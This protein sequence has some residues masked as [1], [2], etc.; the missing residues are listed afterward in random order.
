MISPINQL[1]QDGIFEHLEKSPFFNKHRDNLFT[2]VKMGWNQLISDKV[3]KFDDLDF[4]NY[5]PK[6]YLNEYN[7]LKIIQSDYNNFSFCNYIKGLVSIIIPFHNRSEYTKT[8]FE[9]IILETE[10]PYQV[11]AINNGSNDDTDQL[12][13]DTKVWFEGAPYCIGFE[14]INNI[15]NL[16]FAQSNNLGSSYAKGEFLCFLNND[17]KVTENWLQPLLHSFKDP[18]IGA[19]APLLLYNDN[20]IQHCGTIFHPNRSPE[21]IYNG[22]SRFFPPAHLETVEFQSLT[23]ACL[24]VRHKLYDEIDGFDENY[25]NCFEDI[26]LCLAIRERGYKL[27]YNP[28]SYIFHFESKTPGRKDGEQKSG[29]LLGSKWSRKIVGDASLHYKKGGFHYENGAIDYIERS[30]PA[31]LDNYNRNNL[32]DRDIQLIK[33]FGT[34]LKDYIPTKVDEHHTL[35]DKTTTPLVSIII[36]LFNNL[37]YTRACINSIVKN[38]LYPNYQL[39]LVDNNS[40][41]GTD[42]YLKELKSTLPNLKIITNSE[43]LGFAKANNQGAKVSDG[44]YLLCLNNDTFVTTGWLKNLVELVELDGD[45]VGGGS[46]LLYEDNT[47]QH[48]GVV[49]IVDNVLMPFHNFTNL[50][51]QSSMVSYPKYYNT[52]TAATFLIEKKIFEQIGGFNERYINSFEDMDLCYKIKSLG[53]KLIYSPESIVY[54][55]ESKTAGRKDNV[56]YSA[57]IMREIW[58]GKVGDDYQKHYHLHGL[59]IKLDHEFRSIVVDKT[60]MKL[61]KVIIELQTLI[62]S[63]SYFGS[64]KFINSIKNQLGEFKNKEINGLIEQINY[65]SQKNV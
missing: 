9:S 41:D 29:E 21:H 43:N 5:T 53:K 39:I 19:S 10:T 45:L 40:T 30:I 49:S 27:H 37:H 23:A 35:P 47:I 51:K 8:C 58:N 60:D 42:I 64:L 65:L 54:H 28:R 25:I 12:L 63:G 6:D 32:S 2:E 33:I 24:V 31:L 55:F 17:T 52:L 11:I 4:M 61:E 46:K 38:T 48:S 36:P 18:K 14:V 59:D 22:F 20:T 34:L 15:R 3:F 7:K 1:H 56:A 26:D 57:N 50:D 62:N 44:K 16:N 13:E